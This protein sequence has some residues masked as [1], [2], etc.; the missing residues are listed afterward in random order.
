M[1]ILD[2]HTSDAIWCCAIEAR[3]RTPRPR[4]PARSPRAPRAG[5]RGPCLRRHLLRHHGPR[6]RSSPRPATRS[7]PTPSPRPCRVQDGNGLWYTT[8]WSEA[9]WLQAWSIVARRYARTPNVI[10]V[11]LRNE[12]R[13]AFV[14]RQGWGGLRESAA[15]RRARGD[16]ECRVAAHCAVSHHVS[17][18]SGLPTT[19]LCGR[20]PV[21]PPLPRAAPPAGR[22]R[23]PLW[24]VGGPLLDF[25]T[26]YEKAAAAVLAER[27]TYLVFAQGLVAGSDLRLAAL[28]PLVLRTAWPDGPVVRGQL[29]YEAHEYPWLWVRGGRGGPVGRWSGGIGRASLL[30]GEAETGR[31][32]ADSLPRPCAVAPTAMTADPPLQNLSSTAH[33]KP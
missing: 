11:G 25:A 2:N 21:A 28:R 32:G 12:P 20:L 14:G 24:G 31:Q 16:L 30:M 6:L 8:A 18:A 27:P 13:P 33:P 9:Q 22:F 23:I 19:T 29:A 4:Q 7:Q 15:E 26:A 10:G 5:P 1:V 3:P 17:R